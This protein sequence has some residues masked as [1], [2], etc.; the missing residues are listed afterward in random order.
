MQL[1]EF[2]IFTDQQSLVQLTDQ[3]LHTPWQQKLFSKL[4]GLQFRILYKPGSSNRVADALSRKPAH[5]SV[6]SAVSV[7]TPQWIQE[8][9]DGYSRDSETTDMIAKLSIDPHS[10]PGFSLRDG[11]VRRGA[12][13]WIGANTDLQQRILHA[14]H[15][16]ALG[17]HSGFP[18]TYLRLKQMFYWQGMKSAVR[19]F[20]TSCITCQQAKPDRACLPGLLQPL[21]VPESAWQTISMDFVEG[22]PR[23]GN[24][25]CI[26]VVVDS[27]TKYAHFLPLLH[28]FT[29]A[30]VVMVFLN[31]V[32]RLHGLPSAIISDRD[33]IFTSQFWKELF[34]LADVSLQLSSSYHPQSDGQTERLNQ[35]METFLRCFVNAC[36]AKWS[37]W[38]ALAEFWYNASPHSAI[39][40]SPFEALYGY[41]PRHCGISVLTDVVVHF[42]AVG[43]GRWVQYECPCMQRKLKKRKQRGIERCWAWPH[44]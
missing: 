43:A 39:G 37:S 34:R 13:I 33:K 11:V 20:V 8:V 42:T 32:Y 28:P 23:S 36:P 1:A 7:I 19:S 9:T 3:R 24:A 31:Q 12:Q 17:G 35:T 6:C 16:S 41:P 18:T 38:L 30:S 44:G 10:L 27:F 4:A 22:L 5:D 40:L 15:S 25:N 21:P 26:L 2:T 14:V 29:A